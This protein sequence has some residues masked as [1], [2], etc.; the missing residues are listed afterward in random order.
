[1]ADFRIVGFVS[2]AKQRYI[3]IWL[4]TAKLAV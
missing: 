4:S 1:M 3:L 2:L